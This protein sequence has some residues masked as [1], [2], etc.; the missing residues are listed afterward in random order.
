MLEL[1]EI[2][3]IINNMISLIYTDL[4]WYLNKLET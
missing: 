1:G 4:K 3:F 2:L